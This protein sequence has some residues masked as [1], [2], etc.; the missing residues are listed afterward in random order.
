MEMPDIGA[1]SW[2]LPVLCGPE[3]AP[4]PFFL[5]NS[6]IHFPAMSDADDD[7]DESR[8]INSVNHPI[9][10][11]SNTIVFRVPFKFLNAGRKRILA[12]SRRFLDDAA[13][14]LAN[15]RS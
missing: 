12:E 1:S 5:S 7:H 3:D 13:L 4:Q 14:N 2:K 6:P 10:P 9:I 11:D 8:S 15:Q